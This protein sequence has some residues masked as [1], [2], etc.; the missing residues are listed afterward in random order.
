MRMFVFL[1]SSIRHQ[2]KSYD[3][4][5]NKRS[6]QKPKNQWKSTRKSQSHLNYKLLREQL[7]YDP[8]KLFSKPMGTIDIRLM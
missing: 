1:M 8:L 4:D 5:N 7:I 6:R 3:Y 2:N